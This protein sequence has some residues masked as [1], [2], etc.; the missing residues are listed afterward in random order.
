[1]TRAL[2]KHKTGTA[3]VI[4]IILRPIDLENTPFYKLQVLPTGARAVTSWTNRDEAFLDVTMGVR[5][6]VADVQQKAQPNDHFETSALQATIPPPF[7]TPEKREK[8]IG[9]P[10]NQP[11]KTGKNVKAAL[12]G[13]AAVIIVAP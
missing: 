12:I 1:M 2:A 3:R 6:A 4:P 7:R 5:R 9:I 13:A 10:E 8:N 11:S